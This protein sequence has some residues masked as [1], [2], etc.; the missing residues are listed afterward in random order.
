MAEKASPGCPVR[1]PAAGWNDMLDAAADLR[2]RRTLGSIRAREA[3]HLVQPD[4]VLIQNDSGSDVDAFAVLGIDTLQITAT[5]VA[6]GGTLNPLAW[7]DNLLLSGVEPDIDADSKHIGNFAITLEPIGDGKVGRAA[8]SGLVVAKLDMVYEDH[9][10]ADVADG[11]TVLTSNWY[12]AAE[13]IYKEEVT[14]VWWGIVK[15]GK[16]VSPIYKGKADA[17][18][19]VDDSGTVSIWFAGADTGENVTAYNDWT[20]G[21]IDSGAEI[22]VRYFRDERKWVVVL[23]SGASTPEIGYATLSET[24][25]AAST[26]SIADP[27]DS[28]GTAIAIQTADNDYALCGVS[29]DA[30][31][32]SR[33]TVGEATVWKIIQVLHK[34]KTVVLD[35]EQVG[36]NI[37]IDILDVCV[38]TCDEVES[39]TAIEGTDCEP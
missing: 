20:N 37:N 10:F 27:V 21:I 12:G 9:P 5:A 31:V 24:M 4:I 39:V 29:G 33:A 17:E 2:D 7:A 36:T 35:V 3:R 30:I 1:I 25:C 19:A 8:V 16:F 22:F 38:T 23:G 32:I 26:F 13:I 28:N 15:L 18:I 34:T 6:D 11:T 14:G